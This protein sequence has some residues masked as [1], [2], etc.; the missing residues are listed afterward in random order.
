MQYLPTASTSS[1]L[2]FTQSYISINP[3]LQNSLFLDISNVSL[4]TQYR[5]S[6]IR[7]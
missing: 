3:V 5:P 6:I 7:N 4:F 1:Q 2:P